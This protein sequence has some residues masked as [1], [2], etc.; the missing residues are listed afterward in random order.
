MKRNQANSDAVVA[1][2]EGWPFEK[3]SRVSSGF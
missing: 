2:N 1:I 3:A